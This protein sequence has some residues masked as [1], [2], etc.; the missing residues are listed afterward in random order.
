M[1]EYSIVVTVSL[2]GIF[3]GVN[4]D[5][6]GIFDGVNCDYDEIFDSGDCKLDRNIR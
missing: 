5:Y 3:D 6:D 1:M 2:I 4:C